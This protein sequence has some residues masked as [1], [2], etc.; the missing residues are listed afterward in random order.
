MRQQSMQLIAPIDIDEIIDSIIEVRLRD[1]ETRYEGD[2]EHH[3]V[4]FCTLK[5]YD[6]DKVANAASD[7]ITHSLSDL[8]NEFYSE[9]EP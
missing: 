1:A 6:I 5:S 9:R 3:M 4:N 2:V 7:L 8:F